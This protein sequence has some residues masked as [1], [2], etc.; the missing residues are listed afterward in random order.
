MLIAGFAIH[1]FRPV[2]RIGGLNVF[3][4]PRALSLPELA[5]KAQIHAALVTAVEALR[6][7]RKI[8]FFIKHQLA[9]NEAKISLALHTLHD[10][11]EGIGVVVFL[12]QCFGQ[13]V[14]PSV[15]MG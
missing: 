12:T 15:A 8:E 9:L 11:L 7:K 13:I 1:N 2:W 3:T 10:A 14:F 6:R 5:G 4:A